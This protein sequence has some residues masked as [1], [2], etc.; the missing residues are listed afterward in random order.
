MHHKTLDYETPAAREGRPSLVGVAAVAPF[1]MF[2]VY[3]VGT[4]ALHRLLYDG[5]G[6]SFQRAAAWMALPTG[7]VTFAATVVGVAGW[8]R[9]ARSRPAAVVATFAGVVMLAA[10]VLTALP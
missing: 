3:F 8:I 7:L 5:A 1:V 4:I 6:P 2:A 9:P 10:I